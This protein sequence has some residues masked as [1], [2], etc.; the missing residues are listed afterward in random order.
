[1]K[2]SGEGIRM[3]R[4]V[5]WSLKRDNRIGR[6]GSFGMLLVRNRDALVNMDE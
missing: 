4:V 1:M 5:V 2:G 3:S 6:T